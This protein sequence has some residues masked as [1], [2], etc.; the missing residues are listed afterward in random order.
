[1]NIPPLTKGVTPNSTITGHERVTQASAFPFMSTLVQRFGL[2][3][4]FGL[5]KPTRP[6]TS[7]GV[8][9][10]DLLETR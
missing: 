4:P 5:P 1:M 8:K 10:S 9:G 2:R 7:L 6:F 3:E